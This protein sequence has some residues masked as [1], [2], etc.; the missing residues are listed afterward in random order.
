MT[1]RTAV[2]WLLK[3]VANEIGIGVAIGI[4]T[5]VPVFS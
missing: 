5:A 1:R 4:E 2:I 3:F